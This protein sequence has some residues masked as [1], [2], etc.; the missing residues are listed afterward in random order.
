MEG[1]GFA[2]AIA[3]TISAAMT[4]ITSISANP[5][6]LTIMAIPAT[7]AVIHLCKKIFKTK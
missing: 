7:G 3:D 6:V 5:L 4:T 2:S 1:S